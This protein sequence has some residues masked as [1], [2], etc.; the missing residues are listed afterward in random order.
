MKK[1]FFE[2]FEAEL[3][4]AARLLR[5][6]SHNSNSKIPRCDRAF[7][8]PVHVGGQVVGL[9]VLAECKQ[10]GTD[11]FEF[12]NIKPNQRR[13]LE[14]HSNAGGVSLV[15]LKW[16]GGPAH[17]YLGATWLDYL[18]I[19]ARAGYDPTLEKSPRGTNYTTLTRDKRDEG[20]QLLNRLGGALDIGPLLGFQP[21]YGRRISDLNYSQSWA[22]SDRPDNDP[23]CGFGVA[24]AAMRRAN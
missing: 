24:A 18:M 15:L 20:W 13:N 7:C 10:C 22:D 14:S 21:M 17:I 3:K 5:A 1:A 6:D 23:E 11:R 19:E 9:S 2:D 16:T 4:Q 12:R 8:V